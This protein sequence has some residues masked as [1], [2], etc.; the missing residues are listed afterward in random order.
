MRSKK[1]K[2]KSDI[3]NLACV[4]Q[5]SYQIVVQFLVQHGSI[6]NSQQLL[7]IN[8]P[9][10]GIINRYYQK[11]KRE[12]ELIHCYMTGFSW[13]PDRLILIFRSNVFDRSQ[14]LLIVLKYKTYVARG[15]RLQKMGQIENKQYWYFKQ[16]QDFL[17]KADYPLTIICFDENFD[18]TLKYIHDI[19][20]FKNDRETIFE[21]CV[22]Q[23]NLRRISHAPKLDFINNSRF[24]AHWR[25]LLMAPNFEP[26]QYSIFGQSIKF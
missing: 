3:L 23:E 25:Y 8:N 4:N 17:Q 9:V 6:F 5:S 24:I 7:K 16:K 11:S 13:N 12:I 19:E 21:T 10:G 14:K 1:R 2:T 26:K 18:S 15:Y 20:R 22:P